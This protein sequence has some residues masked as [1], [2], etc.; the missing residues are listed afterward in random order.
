MLLV[1]GDVAQTE[2]LH[3]PAEV[4]DFTAEIDLERESLLPGKVARA[5][6]RPSLRVSQWP[7]P[8]AL[9]EDPRV[10]I[11]VTDR[12]GTTATKTEAIALHDDADTVVELHVP[13]DAARIEVTVRGQIRAVSTQETIEVLASEDADVGGIHGSL[14]TEALHLSA[15]AEGHVLHLLGKTGEP[16]GGRA[17]A[18]TFRHRAVTFEADVT[19]ETDDEGRIELGE[20]RGVEWVK[21]T[22]PSGVSQTWP[23]RREAARPPLLHAIAGEALRI[24]R[25]PEIAATDLTLVELRGAAPLRDASEHLT[26]GER[27]IAIAG[28]LTPGDYALFVRGDPRP[29]RLA[30]APADA[31]VSDGWAAAGPRSLELSPAL[32]QIVAIAIDDAAI[33]VT[34]A[35]AGAQTRVHVIATRF[36]PDPLTGDLHQPTRLPQATAAPPALSRYLSGRDIGDEYRYVLDRRNQPRRPGMLLERPPLLLNPW[37]LR[38]TTSAVQ[39]ARGGGSYGG[40]PRPASPSRASPKIVGHI[41]VGGRDPS[42]AS[43][44]FLLAPAI[45]VANLRVDDDGRLKIA[46]GDLGDAQSVRIVVVDPAFTSDAVIDLPASE[47][48]VRDRRLRHAL[49]P[50]GHFSERRDVEAAPAGAQLIVEDVRSGKVEL[51]DTVARAHQVLVSLGNLEIVREFSFLGQWHALD[52]ATR[53]A[54]YSRYACHELHLFLYFHDRPF[55][56][57]VVGPY[58]AHKRRK[59]FVDRWLLGLDL[60]E[61]CEPWRFA[62][63]NAMELGLLGRRLPEVRG[64]VL[65]LLGDA[66]DRIPPDPER[67]AR[68]VNTLL[69][70]SALEGGGVASA[71][72]AAFSLDEADEFQGPVKEKARKRA[73]RRE[74]ADDAAAEASEGASTVTRA[75]LRA[76]GAPP[77]PPS[78]SAPRGGGGGDLDARSVAADLEERGRAA[79]LYRGADKTQELVETD[80]WRM[81]VEHTQAWLV[82]VNRFWRDF[83]AHEEGPFLSPHLGECAQAYTSALCALAVLGLPFVAGAHEVVTQ[84]ARLTLTCASPS[85]AARTRIVAAELT[86]L[87]SPLL[88]GQSYFRADDRWTWDGAEQQEKY[89][90]GELLV[91]VVYQCQ[92]AVTN[93][94]SRTQRLQILLQIP[95]GSMPVAD[96]FYT[97]TVDVHLGPHGTHAAEYAF[98]FPAPGRFGHVPA[99][100]TRGGELVGHAAPT[101]LEVVVTPTQ[102]DTG[103]W[104]HV[105]QHGSTDEVLAFLDR[106]NLGRIELEKIAWRM[107]DRDAFTRVLELLSDRRHYSDR[108]WAYALLHADRRRVSEWLRTQ[109]ALLRQAGPALSGGLVELDPVERGWYEHLEYAPLVSARAHQLG[110]R[111]QVMNSALAEHLRQF[112]EVVAHRPTPSDDD[113]LAAAHYLF[114]LD[115][116]GD[117][118]ALLARVDRARVATAMQYDYLAAYAACCR[119]DLAAA[120]A[121][122]TPWRD[123]PVDRWRSRLAALLAMLDEA[124]GKGPALAVDEESREQRMDELAAHEPALELSAEGDRV[125]LQH[126]NL[127]R[128]RLRFYRMDIE[129]LFSRQPFVQGDVERFTWI[130]PGAALEVPLAGEG[131]S[132]VELPAA[133]KGQNLV[134]DAVASGLRRS[135][136]HFA[137]DL[138]VQLAHRYGQIRVL[139]A[140]TQAPL[141]ATYVKVYGRQ[142]GG[143][144]Q[145]YKDGYTDLR[146]RFDFTTLSTDDLDRV[147]RFAILVVSDEAGATVLEAPPPPR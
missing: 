115:R 57:R 79:P 18:L 10:E 1:H 15:S 40:A 60:A 67:D 135:I 107:R 136:T 78:R 119:G 128:C 93:P 139:R 97:R 68:L 80:Y 16:R 85:L 50:E 32:P 17:V 125:I 45:V 87:R 72:G 89:V 8:L 137:H 3:H 90:Q 2:R 46:R 43:I 35:D 108:L 33:E 110:D 116:Q 95:R 27:T 124:E 70:A 29:L 73:S 75:V 104:A 62:R 37:A 81:R 58:L 77:P 133:M 105:S 132:V 100:V 63:L 34:I 145:F 30:L 141:P 96:G 42:F 127:S 59:T 92:V 19:L 9:V 48:R 49:D 4:Y 66:V 113:L 41:P 31:V 82:A 142:R 56:D 98:Y 130:E 21:A 14:H 65:R 20:L 52:D 55:F 6:I 144:V 101:E 126:H 111:R 47:L 91:G 146:G 84:D 102:V 61:Y 11:S 86:E 64:A 71:A 76:P 114:S 83:A 44:D 118:L 12:R 140:S 106:A 74:Q 143:A 129:L 69:G 7:A 39:Q 99:H 88:V 131:R 120:R 147:E 38:T 26:I 28:E 123:H 24:P 13:E 53:R 22:L 23:I 54:R 121:A 122:A 112:Y 5:L 25:P 138:A 51:V 117:A 36:A 103:S 109:D 134:I 94:T